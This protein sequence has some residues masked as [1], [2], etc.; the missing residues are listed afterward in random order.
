LIISSSKIWISFDDPWEG[1][2]C[3]KKN[4]GVR[5]KL[6]NQENQKKKITEK[7]ES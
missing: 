2:S 3:P 4:V 5:K 7:T 6:K 1:S